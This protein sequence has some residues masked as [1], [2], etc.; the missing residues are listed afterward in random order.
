[1]L[2]GNEL[3]LLCNLLFSSLPDMPSLQEEYLQD[4][5]ACFKDVHNFAWEQINM[6]TERM[7]TR[8]QGKG[9]DIKAMKCEFQ[10]GEK[11]WLWSLV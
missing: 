2:F 9:F 1:M 5:Q 7:K 11:A 10:E 6:S 3:G 8:Y 4:L